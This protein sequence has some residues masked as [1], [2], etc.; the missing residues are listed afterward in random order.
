M[1]RPTD[2]QWRIATLAL[3]DISTTINLTVNAERGATGGG[4]GL[5][6]QD[7]TVSNN[8]VL[9]AETF[10]VFIRTRNVGTQAFSGG[11]LGIALIDNNGNMEV[12]RIINWGEAN[13]NSTRSNTINNCAVPNTVRPGRYQL[14][15]VIRPGAAEQWRI[16]T[17]PYNDAPTS[18][19]FTVR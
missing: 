1:V 4:Y 10:S 13:P 15:I 2:G 19:D 9:R 18:I 17:W 7:F 6:V 11:N 5:A 3:P 12:I 14:R 8:S 16:A